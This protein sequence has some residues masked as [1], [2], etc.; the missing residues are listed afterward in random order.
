MSCEIYRI[1]PNSN[2]APIS[3]GKGRS[4][5]RY[6]SSINGKGRKGKQKGG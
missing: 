3:F 1:F 4:K 5:G 6:V 2:V